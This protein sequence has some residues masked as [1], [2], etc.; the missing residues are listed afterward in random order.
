VTEGHRLALQVDFP[1]MAAEVPAPT[2]AGPGIEEEPGIG[3]LGPPA[4]VEQ[5]RAYLLRAV[6]VL[7]EEDV[8]PDTTALEALLKSSEARLKEVYR[9]P[10]GKGT[11]C[12]PYCS[13]GVRGGRGGGRNCWGHRSRKLSSCI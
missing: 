9:G 6:P 12:P 2:G 5:L 11:L 4:E 10:S 13:P 3:S 1:V 7:L 8:L